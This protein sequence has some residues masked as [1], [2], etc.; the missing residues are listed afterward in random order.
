MDQFL[1]VPQSLQ[2]SIQEFPLPFMQPSVSPIP[3]LS[4]PLPRRAEMTRYLC[5][6][7]ISEDIL[8]RIMIFSF[9][10]LTCPDVFTVQMGSF[11]GSEL[12]WGIRKCLPLQSGLVWDLYY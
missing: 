3:D 12:W 4:H 2:I 8:W 9:S 1:P 5:S 10:A 11:R 6:L 7:V